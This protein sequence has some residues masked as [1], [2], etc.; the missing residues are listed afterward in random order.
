M[1]Q[2]I[3]IKNNE[4]LPINYVSD[5]D[6]FR[7]GIKYEFKKGINII[8][9]KNGS[10]KSTLL[11]L[12][13][14]YGLCTNSLYSKVGNTLNLMELFNTESNFLYDGI[15]IRSDYLGVIYHYLTKTEMTQE[16]ILGSFEG[17]SLNYLNIRSS[18][19]ESTL[20]SLE[21]LF[22]LSFKNKE[23][24]F[25]IEELIELSKNSNEIWESRLNKLISYYSRNRIKLSSKEDFQYTFLIDE[26]DRNLDINNIESVYKILSYQKPYTQLICVIH[27]P[28]LIYK[29][30]KLDYINFIEMTDNYLDTI[31]KLFKNL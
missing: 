18:T 2:S 8:V 9:G 29:L 1:I 20:N 6:S 21:T 24:T 13:S 12:I 4:N 7:N 25:P 28:I 22:N 31:K 14:Y 5:L 10:G 17:F 27:N 11:K 3:E 19:G 23:I 15:D 16:S 26:P 30:S